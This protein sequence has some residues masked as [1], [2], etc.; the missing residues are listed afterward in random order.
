[1]LREE[2]EE[3]GKYF[4]SFIAL[5][6]QISKYSFFGKNIEICDNKLIN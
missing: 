3:E 2:D 1:M 6:S 5:K 4:F